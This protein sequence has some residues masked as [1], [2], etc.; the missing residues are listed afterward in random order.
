MVGINISVLEVHTLSKV[1]SKVI[2][3]ILF[4]FAAIAEVFVVC[5]NS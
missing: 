5:L 3:L 2:H 4:E 1:G